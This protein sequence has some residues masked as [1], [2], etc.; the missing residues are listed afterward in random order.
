MEHFD[1][2]SF[3]SIYGRTDDVEALDNT[4]ESDQRTPFQLQ[5][6]D[7]IALLIFMVFKEEEVFILICSQN[8][9]QNDKQTLF[10]SWFVNIEKKS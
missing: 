7:N 5:S 3:Q 6:K 2:I 9:V 10:K 4:I 8:D 1:S